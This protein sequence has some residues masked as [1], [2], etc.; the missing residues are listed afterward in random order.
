MQ[1]LCKTHKIHCEVSKGNEKF[2]PFLECLSSGFAE[3]DGA[4]IHTDRNVLKIVPHENQNIVIKSFQILPKARRFVYTYLR[5]SKAKRSYINSV[6]LL[7]LDIPVPEPI[8]FIEFFRGGVLYDSYYVSRKVDYDFTIRKVLNAGLNEYPGL[9][10]AA[11]R[12]V[13]SLHN[14]G[15]IHFDLSPGNL[16]IKRDSAEPH[17]Y[18]VDVNRMKFKSRIGAASGLKN[19]VRLMEGPTHRKVFMSA[20]AEARLLDGDQAYQDL[21]S[22]AESY[23]QRLTLKRRLKKAMKENA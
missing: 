10:S 22:L 19:L 11:A 8:G 17:F 23:T 3:I 4:I 21:V 18:L 14:R 13:A 12:F 15:V 16:L 9:I 5:E 1:F 2:R 7:A 6:R 20:Y